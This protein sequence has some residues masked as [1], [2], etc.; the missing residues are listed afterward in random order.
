MWFHKSVFPFHLLLFVW[1]ILIVK[2]LYAEK[3]IHFNNM[4]P[5]FTG[6]ELLC[7]GGFSIFHLV[8]LRSAV[9]IVYRDVSNSLV[10]QG[11]QIHRVINFC[12]DITIKLFGK[13][14]FRKMNII[15]ALC[16]Q[17]TA[18]YCK[19]LNNNNNSSNSRKM[20]VA[21]RCREFHFNF[22]YK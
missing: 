11:F 6:R 8:L 22:Q 2:R 17:S 19:F 10:L 15:K 3:W 13:Y 4:L 1:K 16:T 5:M 9:C 20:W 12:W 21:W 7:F 18:P 14:W